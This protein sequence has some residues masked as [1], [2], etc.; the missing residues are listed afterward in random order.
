MDGSLLTLHLGTFLSRQ[1]PTVEYEVG[2]NTVVF[3]K[4]DTV[5]YIVY[6]SIPMG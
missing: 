6:I 1:R 4:A 2:R 3:Q 5:D